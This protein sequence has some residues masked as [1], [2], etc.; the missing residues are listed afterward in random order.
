[1]SDDTKDRTRITLELDPEDYAHLE[2]VASH[3]KL[4]KSDTLR[5]LIRA[6]AR[7]LSPAN[8]NQPG[9]VSA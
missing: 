9:V 8:E 3:E 2:T 4:T 7:R 6:E 1:M 5:R